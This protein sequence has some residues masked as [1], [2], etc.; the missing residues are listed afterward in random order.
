MSS[1]RKKVSIVAMALAALVLAGCE[2]SY[3][4]KNLTNE[5][6]PMLKNTLP[7]VYAVGVQ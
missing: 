6:P 3:T 4:E 1:L 5:P 7:L 2:T